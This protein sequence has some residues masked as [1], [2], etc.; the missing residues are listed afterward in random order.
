MYHEKYAPWDHFPK[1][2]RYYEIMN[3]FIVLKD[4]FNAASVDAH[5][6]DLKQWRDCVITSKYYKS[7]NGAPGELIF[8]H[9]LNVKLIEALYLLLLEYE[10]RR[11][12]KQKASMEQIEKEKQE[13]SFFPPNLCQEDL[14]DPYQ[15]LRKLFKKT[16]PQ[17]YRDLLEDWLM[18]GL[19]NKPIDE[20]VAP[21]YIV[22]LYENL[23]KMYELGW[24]IY[25]REAESPELKKEDQSVQ[26][27][28]TEKISVVSSPYESKS[29]QVFNLNQ[30]SF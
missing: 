3:P 28:T 29:T 26:N 14:T 22:R 12:L 19:Y 24:L 30:T 10:Y 9:S 23:L 4:F 17:A 7:R 25:Q 21:K 11:F 20:G 5:S 18:Y 8:I 13:W 16:K 15:S 1:T 2:L 6:E 27:T